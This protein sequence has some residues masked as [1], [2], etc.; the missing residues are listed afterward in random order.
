MVGNMLT[1]VAVP[2]FVLETTGSAAKTGI[3]AFFTALPAVLAAFFGGTFVDRLGFKKT[4]VISDVLSG[5]TVGLI[6]LLHNTVGLEFWMLLVLVFLG[7]LFDAPGVTAR[8]SLVPDLAERGDVPVHR[9]S[10]WSD[11]TNRGA[12]FLGPPIAGILVAA[13]GPGNV[14]YVD[15]ATFAVSALLI[16]IVMPS[17]RHMSAP[18]R[19]LDDLK[20]GLRYLRGDRLVFVLTITVMI[21][22]TLDAAT[23][24]VVLPVYARR[25][26]GS[27][28]DLG[29]MIGLFGAGALTASLIYGWIGARFPQRLLFIAGF[30]L[31]SARYWLLAAYPPLWVILIGNFI[32]G[33][34]AGALNPIMATVDYKRIPP[35][36]RG[37]VLGAAY[38]GS[39]LGMP[40]G[41]LAGGFLISWF[42]LTTT[43]ICLGTLYGITTLAMIFHKSIREMDDLF[44][45]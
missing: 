3:T 39:Y 8:A 27:A 23:S 32:F 37:R 13:L 11:S 1:I 20:A 28:V 34:G 36:M 19:Y 12:A 25:V 24:S 4:S 29:L 26:L 38:A 5:V 6:P 41:G 9:A 10:A 22:N 40:L 35:D 17:I 2:W 16:G 31:V 33:M 45:D 15:A 7:A 18:S 30:V 43:L 42:G 21:T 44:T 14:L